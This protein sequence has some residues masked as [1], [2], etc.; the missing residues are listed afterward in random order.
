MFAN[1]KLNRFFKPNCL[2]SRYNCGDINCY[3]DLARLRGVKYLT[4]QDEK[5]LTRIE[6]PNF[7]DGKG[8]H[9]KHSN[10]EFDAS[11]FLR[12]VNECI[13][14]IKTTKYSEHDEF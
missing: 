4:W 2:L 13:S 12:L 9:L 5:K 6:D 3:A 10:Y 1:I 8:P 14:F 7:K 11:E